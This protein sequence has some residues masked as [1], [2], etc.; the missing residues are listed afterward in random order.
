MYILGIMLVSESVHE[1]NDVLDATNVKNVNKWMVPSSSMQAPLIS[2][3][4][5]GFYS[6]HNFRIKFLR[7]QYERKQTDLTHETSAPRCDGPILH[8]KGSSRCYGIQR[9]NESISEEKVDLQKFLAS[10][11]KTAHSCA[12]VIVKIKL[13]PKSAKFRSMPGSLVCQTFG[14]DDSPTLMVI[15]K[16][17]KDLNV[18]WI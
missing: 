13:Y 4:I 1:G 14:I 10:F 18:L 16:L 6:M 11:Q 17:C 3:K 15:N 2:S 8:T 7:F 12:P 5:S 9:V